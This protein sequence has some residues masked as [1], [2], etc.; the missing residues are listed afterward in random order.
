[1]TGEA[2]SP[3]TIRLDKWLWAARFFKTRQ[4][5]VE[6]INGGKVHVDGLRAKPGKAVR[7]GD[8]LTIHKG[9][10]AWELVVRGISRQRR[11]A[12]EAALLYEEDEASRLRRQ[13]LVRERREQ[14]L[15]DPPKGRPTKR[16]RREIE[17][18]RRG[19]ET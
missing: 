3:E 9:S 12:P 15:G 14:G 6:A 7:V 2:G 11:G 13:A 18:F 4:L 1:M 5:A 19:A 16:D 17:R 10:L 8:R